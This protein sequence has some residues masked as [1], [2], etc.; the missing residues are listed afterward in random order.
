MVSKRFATLLLLLGHAAGSRDA[1]GADDDTVAQLQ[2]HSSQYPQQHQQPNVPTPPPSCKPSEAQLLAAFIAEEAYLKI[3]SGEGKTARG[4]LTL[5]GKSVNK[6]DIFTD[7]PFR[8]SASMEAS[9]FVQMFKDNFDDNSGGFPNAVISGGTP[10]GPRRANIV[11]ESASYR[12]NTVTF[13]WSSDDDS[14]VSSLSFGTASLFI[15]GFGCVFFHPLSYIKNKLCSEL[16]GKLVTKGIGGLACASVDLGSLGLCAAI[17]AETGDLLLPVCEGAVIAVCQT[18]V[19]KFSEEVL[20]E[21]SNGT[22]TIDAEC[23][24][25]GYKNPC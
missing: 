5:S 8:Y 13:D 2:L 3:E 9:G 6:V 15:D 11:L 20:K 12:T 24:K 21:L 22:V 7:R 4:T 17:T 19:A 23:N 1:C 10:D 18:L 16:A 14:T 25:L